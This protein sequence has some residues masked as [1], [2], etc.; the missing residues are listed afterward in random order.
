MTDSLHFDKSQ[1]YDVTRRR[2]FNFTITRSL[3]TGDSY[4]AQLKVFSII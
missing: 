1:D 2:S 3:D 4:D